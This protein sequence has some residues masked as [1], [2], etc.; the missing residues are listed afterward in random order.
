MDS[1]RSVPLRE[2]LHRCRG[3]TRPLVDEGSGPP[4]LLL[5]GN[6]TWSFLYRG[7][8]A[9]LKD[10]FRCIALDYPGFGLSQA[11]PDYSYTPA[12]HA[13]IVEGFLQQLDLRAVRMMVQ[14]LLSSWGR[15]ASSRPATLRQKEALDVRG[16]AG[17]RRGGRRLV[18]PRQLRAA[19]LDRPGSRCRPSIQYDGFEYS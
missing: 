5:H 14:G 16:L 10:R 1:P 3:G 15:P 9:G 13:S 2:P 4:L 19:F 11:P 12:E 6:P 7:V 17:K 8:I 18:E